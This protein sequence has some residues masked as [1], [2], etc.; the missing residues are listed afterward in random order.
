VALNLNHQQNSLN[1]S[2]IKDESPHNKRKNYVL[3]LVWHYRGWGRYWPHGGRGT[4]WTPV[5][6]LQLF[7]L[8]LYPSHC[9]PSHCPLPHLPAPSP[10]NG[11]S[12]NPQH[13]SFIQ[14][15]YIK[16]LQ[17]QVHPLPLMPDKIVQLEEHIPQTGNSFR[18]SIPPGVGGPKWRPSCTS[19]TYVQGKGTE[20]D[21]RA[22]TEESTSVRSGCFH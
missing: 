12:P 11:W 16:S 6:E 17:D 4:Q 1:G 3:I 10:L 7:L 15:W 8:A 20:R 19:V 13:S 9:F 22:T 2:F 14:P 21:A 18:D 5:L